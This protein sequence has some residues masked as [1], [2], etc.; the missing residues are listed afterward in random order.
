MLTYCTWTHFSPRC[1]YASGFTYFICSNITIF[2]FLFLN[3]Y[4][5]SYKKRNVEKEIKDEYEKAHN[6]VKTITNGVKQKQENGVRASACKTISNLEEV[7]IDIKAGGDYIHDSN[8]FLS[9]RTG[10]TTFGAE[11]DFDSIMK[12]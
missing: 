9:R 4:S 8:F 11:Y 7:P 10:K 1:Q 3:F 6:G 5:K 12:K 2:L